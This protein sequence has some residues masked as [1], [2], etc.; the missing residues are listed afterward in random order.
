MN[1][2]TENAFLP[3]QKQP[4]QKIRQLIPDLDTKLR[5]QFNRNKSLLTDV[6][7][8]LTI[9]DEG[10]EMGSQNAGRVTE[11]QPVYFNNVIYHM[12]RTG[13]ASIDNPII[14]ALEGQSEEVKN[15]V[16]GIINQNFLRSDTGDM[17]EQERQDAISLGLATVKHIADNYMEG[18]TAKSF[19]QAMTKLANIASSG[20]REEDGTMDY[21]LPLTYSEKTGRSIQLDESVSSIVSMMRE[22]DPE[23]YAKYKECMNA[24]LEGDDDSDEKLYKALRIALDF[25]INKVNNDP[26]VF[27]RYEWEV[28]DR[29]NNT[30]TDKLS[31]T[32]AGIEAGIGVSF[33][34]AIQKRLNE[35]SYLHGDYWDYQMFL[36]KKVSKE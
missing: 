17:T 31:D 29:V 22:Y 14:D 2:N 28:Y 4:L 34:E 25:I 13:Y 1:V 21:C 23:A 11:A 8:T 19:M 30:S 20:V 18:D 12:T 9:S 27:K 16:Y 36:L 26:D 35:T 7:A 5:S 32:F 33:I 15:Y 10:R 6:A 24:F 3:G